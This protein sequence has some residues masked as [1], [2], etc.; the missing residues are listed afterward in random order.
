MLVGFFY[1]QTDVT[2]DK[3]CPL[4]NK[5]IKYLI[6]SCIDSSCQRC[7]CQNIENASEKVFNIQIL[8]HVRSEHETM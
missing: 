4:T 2:Y 5:I 1:I 6:S 8:L 3:E 7:T